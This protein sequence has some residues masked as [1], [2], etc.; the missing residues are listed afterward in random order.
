MEKSVLELL[1]NIDFGKLTRI[2]VGLEGEWTKSVKTIWSKDTDSIFLKDFSITSFERKPCIELCFP[3]YWIG[4]HCFRK[5]EEYCLD[6]VLVNEII[7][8]IKK[9]RG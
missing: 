3:F 8:F 5:N 9:K 2:D 1:N 7:E 4:I 6:L